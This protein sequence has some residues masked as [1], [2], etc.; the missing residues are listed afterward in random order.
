MLEIGGDKVE[1]EE[2]GDD[3]QAL[4]LM[5]EGRREKQEALVPLAQATRTLPLPP[6]WIAEPDWWLDRVSP[7]TPPPSPPSPQKQVKMEDDQQ[8]TAGKE[9]LVVVVK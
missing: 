4:V 8:E 9:V 7:E 5:E 2:L 6:L 1:A 3:D